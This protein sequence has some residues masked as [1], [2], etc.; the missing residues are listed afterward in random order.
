ML[1]L[2]ALP[3]VMPLLLEETHDD[4]TSW[5]VYSIAKGRWQVAVGKGVDRPKVT[6]NPDD[7]KRLEKVANG[8]KANGL[9]I[10]IDSIPPQLTKLLR[11]ESLD[12]TTVAADAPSSSQARTPDERLPCNAC[13]ATQ[14]P[15]VICTGTG[16]NG[17]GRHGQ[18]TR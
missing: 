13:T 4:G 6:V 10:T 8:L 12:G 5:K 1:A 2:L 14:Q 11:D 17:P 9:N 18:C 3:L 16:V 15:M 7:P